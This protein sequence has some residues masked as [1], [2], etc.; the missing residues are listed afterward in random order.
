VLRWLKA[1]GDL[2][3]VGREQIR[4]EALGKQRDAD[5]TQEIITYLTRAGW[6]RQLPAPSGEKG[7]RPAMRW[8]VNPR[9]LKMTEAGNLS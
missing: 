4:R 3:Q 8:E 6:L 5:D 7:G 9:L 2:R 1:K